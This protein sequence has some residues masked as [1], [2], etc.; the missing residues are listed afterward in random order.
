MKT[1]NYSVLAASLA[2]R[3]VSRAART[4][5]QV[6]LPG[7]MRCGTTLM[8]ELLKLHPNF[9]PPFYDTRQLFYLQDLPNLKAY[10][11]TGVAKTLYSLLFGG[12]TGPDSYRKFFPLKRKMDLIRK[13][14]GYPA[15]TG[16]FTSV[17]LHCR[18]AAQRIKAITPDAKLIIML[19]DPVQRAYSEYSLMTLLSNEKRRFET[20]IEDELNNKGQGNY[21]IDN[22]IRKGLYESWIR[23]YFE[24]FDK[25]QML[26]VRSEDFFSDPLA[27]A[28]NVIAFIGLPP[29]KTEA[30]FNILDLP[31]NAI[32]YV[33][34]MKDETRTF[35]KEYYRPYNQRLFEFLN[36]DMQ[37]D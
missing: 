7:A 10:N 17:Y 29:L 26:I 30:D 9:V 19:R 3:N 2:F 6:Y 11:F 14:T 15:V 12:Y 33:K 35:L 25:E 34:R 37:W 13:R 22:Y 31:R 32:F 36:V 8:Y 27:V 21:F 5:P 28:A 24:L 18:V 4:M 20:A 16:D 1:V 23:P